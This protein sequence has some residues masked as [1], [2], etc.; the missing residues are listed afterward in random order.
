MVISV[1][2]FYLQRDLATVAVI[3]CTNSADLCKKLERSE[4]LLYYP[5]GAFPSQPEKAVQLNSLDAKEIYD[6]ILRDLVPGLPVLSSSELKVSRYL[7]V[8]CLLIMR[9]YTN[10]KDK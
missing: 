7:C 8:K 3:D 1:F 2:L 9:T 5:E 10:L 6:Q 4:E